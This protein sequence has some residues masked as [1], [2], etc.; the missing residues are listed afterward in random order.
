MSRAL[1]EAAKHQYPL[2]MNGFRAFVRRFF[3]S[4]MACLEVHFNQSQ[5]SPGPLSPRPKNAGDVNE[6]DRHGPLRVSTLHFTSYIL[7]LLSLEVRTTSSFL[8]I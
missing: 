4:W 7:R 8:T 3:F 5:I 1:M 6:G 2:R